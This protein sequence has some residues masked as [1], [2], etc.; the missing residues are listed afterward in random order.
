MEYN[1]SEE[2]LMPISNKLVALAQL[3]DCSA[4]APNGLDDVGFVGV[5]EI[6]LSIEKEMGTICTDLD[7]RI[8][9]LAKG[10]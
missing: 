3:F 10:E 1:I 7:K 5:G 2:A 6:L 4:N 8:V 9:K